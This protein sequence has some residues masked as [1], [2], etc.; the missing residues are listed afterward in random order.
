M[1]GPH[2]AGRESQSASCGPAN[3]R[4]VDEVK[5]V[6]SP[7]SWRQ[8]SSRQVKQQDL[9]VA[10]S[11]AGPCALPVG[12]SAF[13]RCQKHSGHVGTLPKD[14]R[15]NVLGCVLHCLLRH[16][17]IVWNEV[18]SSICSRFSVRSPA[19]TDWQSQ[20]GDDEAVA[21]SARS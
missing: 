13:M 16:N 4:G 9:S 11:P 7:S 15:F 3:M 17:E 19:W 2:V 1:S 20:R 12:Q 14:E 8:D 21:G 6:L 10:N 5:E 18:H